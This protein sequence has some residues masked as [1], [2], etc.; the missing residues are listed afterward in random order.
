MATVF[1]LTITK[2]ATAPIILTWTAATGTQEDNLIDEIW[3]AAGERDAEGNLLNRTA[4]R[5]RAAVSV[6]GRAFFRQALRP[7]M[8]RAQRRAGI[9]SVPDVTVTE[10]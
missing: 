1:Q 3:E 4:A 7:W 10:S 8:R 2:D 6:W 9:A 5:L